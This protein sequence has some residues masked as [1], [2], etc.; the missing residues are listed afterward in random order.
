MVYPNIYFISILLKPTVD[1]DWFLEEFSCTGCPYYC[2][3]KPRDGCFDLSPQPLNIW[4]CSLNL[5]VILYQTIQIETF[6]WAAFLSEIGQ[7]FSFTACRRLADLSQSGHERSTTCPKRNIYTESCS[8]PVA[9]QSKLLQLFLV[10]AKNKKESF[11]CPSF[12]TSL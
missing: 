7:E 12:M 10:C 9:R 6:H 8:P 3:L 5:L 4:E 1:T 2:S 11:C